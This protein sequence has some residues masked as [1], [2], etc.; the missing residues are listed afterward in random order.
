MNEF[1]FLYRGGSRDG[2][3]AEMQ[4]VMQKALI[5]FYQDTTITD[6]AAR[7]ADALGKANADAAFIKVEMLNPTPEAFEDFGRTSSTSAGHTYIPNDNLE[8][9]S[10]S[11]EG[12]HS[13]YSIQDANALKIKVTYGYQLKVPLM[14]FV[15][16]AIMCGPSS[17]ITEIEAFGQGYSNTVSA[18]CANFYLQG[19]VPLVTYATV[20][21]QT[22]AWQPDG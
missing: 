5:P 21:M 16:R 9:R 6:D 3:P 2:S 7:L 11:F 18:D 8:Y 12:S 19:R 22:P 1:V 20:Q 14:Q 15:V 10:H 17:G 13:H 4:Q